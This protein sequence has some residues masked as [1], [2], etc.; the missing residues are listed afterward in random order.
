MLHNGAG[1]WSM[2]QESVDLN[3]YLYAEAE[4]LARIAGILGKPQ[5][6]A[7]WRDQAA[8]LKHAI[9]TRMFDAKA[10]WFFDLMSSGERVRVYG[11]EGW[12]PLWTGAATS[13]QAGAVAKLMADPDKFGTPLP[14]LARDDPHFSPIKGYW[15]GPVWLDQALFGIEGL[16]RYG[17]GKLADRLA[18]R[19]VDDANGLAAQAPFYENYDPLTGHGYQ[20][21]NFSWSAASYLLLLHAGI[22]RQTGL[23]KH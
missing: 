5:D 12:S 20:S 11:S 10:G 21:R 4:G 16:Q 19:L 17:F 9:Q 23:G 6:R 7:Q 15:R 18:L 13:A 1:A 14:L 8:R 22:G 2:D 3:S